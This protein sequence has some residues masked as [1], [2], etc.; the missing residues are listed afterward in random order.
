MKEMYSTPFCAPSYL[1]LF[2]YFFYFFNTFLFLDIIFISLNVFPLSP[3][4]FLD[5]FD[6]PFLWLSALSFS[7][8]SVSVYQLCCCFSMND[9]TE[10]RFWLSII[11]LMLI[12]LFNLIIQDIFFRMRLLVYNFCR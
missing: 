2:Y 10:T 8:F 1:C 3:F 6:P 7:I 5:P 9:K 11:F 12:S 4:K